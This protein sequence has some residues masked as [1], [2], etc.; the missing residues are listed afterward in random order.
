[1][2]TKEGTKADILEE[3]EGV[4]KDIHAQIGAEQKSVFAKYPL[5]F[6]L[7]ATFGAA[8]V[9]HGFEGVTDMIPFLEKNP[10]LLFIIG[11]VILFFTGRLY[12][13][14]GK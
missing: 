13:T 10:L 3:V 4:V 11:L 2:D 12:R 8:S 14:L 1:M 7:L 5:T 9:I 6:S